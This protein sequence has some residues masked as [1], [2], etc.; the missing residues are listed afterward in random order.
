MSATI[1][2]KKKYRVGDK[3]TVHIC[4]VEEG[5]NNNI[6]KDKYLLNSSFK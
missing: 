6:Y 3:I 2:Y 5:G 4:T 1:L